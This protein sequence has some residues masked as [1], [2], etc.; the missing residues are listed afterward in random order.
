MHTARQMADT[1]R[2]WLMQPHHAI[3][4]A[5]T[6]AGAVTAARDGKLQ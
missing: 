1:S 2:W 4:E 3:A 6:K 5:L